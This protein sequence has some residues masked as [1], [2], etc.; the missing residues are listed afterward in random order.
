ML[1]YIIIAVICCCAGYSFGF[2]DAKQNDKN[3]VAR[4]VDQVGGA[5]R[6]QM[7]TDVDGTMSTLD[8]DT[9]AHKK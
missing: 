9:T 5:T 2:Q 3:I 7:K 4:W 8:A 6:D 1:R